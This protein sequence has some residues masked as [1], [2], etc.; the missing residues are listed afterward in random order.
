[1]HLCVCAFSI[2]ICSRGHR[3]GR[4]E[5]DMFLKCSLEKQGG[6]YQPQKHVSS[7]QVGFARG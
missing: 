1:M 2:R 7:A 5:G 3:N 4:V 6:G